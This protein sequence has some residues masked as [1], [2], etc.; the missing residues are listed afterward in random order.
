MV[1]DC[2]LSGIFDQSHKYK[3]RVHVRSIQW[4]TVYGRLLLCLSAPL[5]ARGQ[6]SE[7][8]SNRNLR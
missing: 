3:R 8:W 7:W 6:G 1:R 4:A 2:Q 5:A